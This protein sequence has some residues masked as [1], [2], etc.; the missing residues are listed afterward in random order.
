MYFTMPVAWRPTDVLQS[1][2]GA[3]L[4]GIAWDPAILTF[5]YSTVYISQILPSGR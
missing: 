4:H 2:G 5:A 3:A 1:I